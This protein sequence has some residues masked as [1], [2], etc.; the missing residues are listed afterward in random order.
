MIKKLNKEKIKEWAPIIACIAAALSALAAFICAD[1]LKLAN[2]V[3]L[4][5]YLMIN[6]TKNVLLYEEPPFIVLPYQLKNC[7][8]APALKINKGYTSYLVEKSGKM[9]LVQ[10]FREPIEKTDAL[11]P[12][13][14]SAVHLDNIN[15]TGFD[16]EK[17]TK[18]KVELKITYQGFEEVDKRTRYS[19]S[20]LELY[21]KKTPDNKI[22]FIVSQ[23]ALDFGFE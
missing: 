1:Q 17:I 21:P 2:K 16:I 18:I 5:P 22:V 12:D 20:I 14:I 6:N 10:N 15:I 7:G 23:P 9:E 13:Q 11:L 19:K 3:H 8:S 4:S